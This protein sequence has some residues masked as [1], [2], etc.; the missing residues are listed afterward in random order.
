MLVIGAGALALANVSA[1]VGKHASRR[2]NSVREVAHLRGDPVGSSTPSDRVKGSLGRVGAVA[3]AVGIGAAVASM[4]A[5]AFA[6]PTGPG[7]EAGTS[8][9]SE[10]APGSGPAAGSG[11]QE[12]GKPQKRSA[13]SAKPKSAAGTRKGAGRGASDAAGPRA[14]V[15]GIDSVDST[16]EQSGS[17][18]GD[19]A[20]DNVPEIPSASGG[21]VSSASSKAAVSVG[22]EGQLVPRASAAQSSAPA[23]PRPSWCCSMAGPAPGGI[24]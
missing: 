16:P 2:T 9:A 17:G 11:S 20:V 21:G 13:R 10:T 8:S 18:P 14:K 15:S 12:G 3:V 7:A 23:A 1:H 24:G 22:N 5:V 19:S 4:P 6:D